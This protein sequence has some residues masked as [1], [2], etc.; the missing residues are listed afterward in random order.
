MTGLELPWNELS[1]VHFPKWAVG[2]ASCFVAVVTVGE[3]KEEGMEERR[4]RRKRTVG[5]EE[6][7]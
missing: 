6:V 3:E 1:H 5:E 2:E 7:V 4:D